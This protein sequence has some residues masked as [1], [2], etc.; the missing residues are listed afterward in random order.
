[1]PALIEGLDVTIERTITN[2]DRTIGARLGGAIALEHAGG[3]PRGTITLELTGSAGQSFG[4][5]CSPGMTLRLDG[6]A[7]DGVGK[8]MA[9]GRIAIRPPANDAGDPV[10]V[11][12]AALYGATGGA[13]FV[14]GR[15]GERFGV[16]NSGADAVVEGVGLHACE[17]MTGGTVVILGSFG[18]NLGA[19]MT[20]GECFVLDADARL[21][22]RLNGQLVH[23]VRPDHAAMA[24]L[25]ALLEEQVTLTGSVRASTLLAAW[26]DTTERFWRIVP[27]GATDRH[28]RLAAAALVGSR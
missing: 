17:Y 8:A 22:M 10:L 13:L 27:L 6:D 15:A 19:G 20:G 18:H 14:A 24:R 9:G 25:Q 11:G 28:E 4:A 23:A 2:R 12:N 7:N 1:L 5:F 16:R 21:G 26:E 3:L